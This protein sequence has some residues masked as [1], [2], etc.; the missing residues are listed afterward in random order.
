MDTMIPWLTRLVTQ[1]R[2]LLGE[3]WWPYG[4]AANRDAI[5][6]VPRYNYQQGITRRR[7]SIEDIFLPYLLDT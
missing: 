3:D 2:E 5:G 1:D 4:I 6:A 7:F